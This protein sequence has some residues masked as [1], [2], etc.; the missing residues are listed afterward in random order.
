MTQIL[1]IDRLEAIACW[2]RQGI[3]RREAY[4]ALQRGPDESQIDYMERRQSCWK[5]VE[6][7]DALVKAE[8]NALGREHGGVMHYISSDSEKAK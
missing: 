1:R 7:A 3:L 6:S 2:A 8:L 5:Q 4:E